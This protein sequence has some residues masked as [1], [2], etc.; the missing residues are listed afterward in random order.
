MANVPVTYLRRLRTERG[1][2]LQ[3]LASQADLSISY[4]SELERD[5][6]K[7]PSADVLRRI[8]EKLELGESDRALLFS[9]YEIHEARRKACLFVDGKWLQIVA[10]PK[11]AERLGGSPFRLDFGK[12]PE[13]LG[14]QFGS[15]VT[16]TRKCFSFSSAKNIHPAD[17]VREQERLEES[18]NLLSRLR[19]IY[20][21]DV[22]DTPTDY[23][24]NHL[25]K[26]LRKSSFV[27]LNPV[28]VALTAEAL[29]R[30]AMADRIDVAIFLLGDAVYK[31][32]LTAL[33]QLGVQVAL[34]SLR[35]ACDNA[36]IRGEEQT[37]DWP[38]VW[39]DDEQLL[40][41]LDR[42]AKRR[43][44]DCDSK[45]HQGSQRVYTTDE[46]V[47]GQPFYCDSCRV[48]ERVSEDYERSVEEHGS[49]LP[50]LDGRV[51]R[52]G[53]RGFGMIES[54]EEVF[55]FHAS[56]CFPES[57]FSDLT[58]NSSVRFSVGALP[59]DNPRYRYGQALRVRRLSDT[60]SQ[61]VSP[62]PDSG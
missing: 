21:W 57:S 17:E 61:A 62:Q 9:Q 1:V 59:G 37:L 25:R 30:A 18:R 22:L 4:L 54:A 56:S 20:R 50:E 46:E 12:L 19:S 58:V 38:P 33:R 3:W 39:I 23:R 45:H 41:A 10:I 44:V 5:E 24:G 2:T 55:F 47:P 8:A 32:C 51:V 28:P 34:V 53:P 16:V 52:T 49:D 35:G 43:S 31:P 27:P 14:R 42:P 40:L 29:L 7:R 36:L 60:P 15:D 6:D 11:I 48:I 13:I 26:E